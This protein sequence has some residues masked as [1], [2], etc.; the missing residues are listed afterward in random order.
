MTA[1]TE[2][3]SPL[4]AAGPAPIPDPALSAVTLQLLRQKQSLSHPPRP[5]CRGTL[6]EEHGNSSS[7]FCTLAL[8]SLP[9][10]ALILCSETL[11]PRWG[12]A[13]Q[14]GWEGLDASA[15]PP[16]QRTLLRGP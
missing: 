1:C 16:S 13:G 3:E 7:Q 9:T 8:K 15:Q 4:M 11:T 6:L 12:Q 14:P 5:G 10:Q 2:L